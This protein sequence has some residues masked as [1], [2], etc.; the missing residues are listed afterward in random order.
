MAQHFMHQYFSASIVINGHERLPGENGYVYVGD[1]K[2]EYSIVLTN[3][4]KLYCC[5]VEIIVGELSMGTFRVPENQSVT[6]K[7]QIKSDQFAPTVKLNVC[8]YSM[9]IKELRI[10]TIKKIIF[11]ITLML[12]IILMTIFI[13]MLFYLIICKFK[14]IICYIFQLF[15]RHVIDILIHYMR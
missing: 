4:H 2:N 14:N 9:S 10:L 6:I 1:A 7:E 8:C 5:D 12:M 3:D 11:N 13:M 15:V